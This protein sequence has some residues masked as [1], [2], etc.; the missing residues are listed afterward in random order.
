M[1]KEVESFIKNINKQKYLYYAY[2]LTHKQYESEDLLQESIKTA[3]EKSLLFKEGNI[4][5]WFY[6]IMRN[7]FIDKYRRST[8]MIKV[9]EEYIPIIECHINFEYEELLNKIDKNEINSDYA[10]LRKYAEGFSYEELV[11]LYKKP[12]GTIKSIIHRSRQKIK[13]KYDR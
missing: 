10:I 12:M 3:I 9:G 5:G 2:K 6:T 13:E 1:N 4:E 7:T 8:K 11:T